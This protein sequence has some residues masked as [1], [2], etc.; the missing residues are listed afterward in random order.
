MMH[1]SPVVASRRVGLL[2]GAFDPPHE[3][4][5]RLAQLAWDNLMLD[6]LRFVPARIA[7]MKQKSAAP[8]GMRL[9]MLREMLDGTPYTIDDIELGLGEVSYTVKTLEA[10]SER[11]PN[12]A[13]ILIM[14]SDQAKAF[15]KWF[16][17]ERILELASVAVAVRP[18]CEGVSADESNSEPAL[19]AFLSV[20]LSGEWSGKPGHTILL[21]STELG[22][23]SSKIRGQLA[24]RQNPVGLSEKVLTTIL[25]QKL[26]RKYS[27]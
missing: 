1:S 11:E 23:A 14:G 22:L 3:G 27:S 8:A 12:A 17:P 26:Y 5:L 16:D 10:C 4:H 9:A 20:R 2:G 18:N 21:P 19:P 15:E 24:H 6:E 7:P 13:W 25:R